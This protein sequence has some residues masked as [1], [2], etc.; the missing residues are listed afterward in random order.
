MP[1]GPEPPKSGTATAR[2]VATRLAVILIVA[3]A[4]YVVGFVPG[5]SKSRSLNRRVS[6]LRRQLALSEIENKLAAAALEA[7]LGRHEQAR[8]SASQFFTRLRDELDHDKDSALSPAQRDQALQL[9]NQ[10]DDIITLLA[11]SDPSSSK[12]LADLYVA[13]RKLTPA[14]PAAPQ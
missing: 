11:R 12:K 14:A 3:V 13:F 8:Q 7:N 2:P 10:R 4:A 5:W 9:L 6:D 1:A